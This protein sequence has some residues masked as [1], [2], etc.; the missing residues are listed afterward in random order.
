LPDLGAIHHTIGGRGLPENN[1][2]YAHNLQWNVAADPLQM[3]R[4]IH[5]QNNV[6]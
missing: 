1:G 5:N 3:Q 2:E 4:G 6:K